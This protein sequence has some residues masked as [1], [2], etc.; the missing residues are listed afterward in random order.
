MFKKCCVLH[1]GPDTDAKESMDPYL[2]SGSGS[3][4]G[5]YEDKKEM[6]WL[7]SWVSS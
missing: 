4:L 2:G 5:K 1:L 3:G 6:P 7:K